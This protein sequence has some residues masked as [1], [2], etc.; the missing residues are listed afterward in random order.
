MQMAVHLNDGPIITTQY[1]QTK[2]LMLNSETL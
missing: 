2:A 1:F